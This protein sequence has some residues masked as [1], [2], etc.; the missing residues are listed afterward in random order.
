M[1]TTSFIN[2]QFQTRKM[3]SFNPSV[4]LSRSSLFDGLPLPSSFA[5]QNMFTTGSSTPTRNLSI[6][7]KQGSKAKC[8]ISSGDVLPHPNESSFTIDKE[9][10][11]HL[12]GIE[13]QPDMADITKFS[14]EIAP[15]SK[16]IS[17]K[18]NEYDLESPTRGFSSIPDAIEDIRQGK[19]V[20][21][22]D[23]EDRENEGDLIMAASLVTPQAMA[24]VVKHGTGIVCVS[25]R[26]DDLERLQLPLMVKQKENDDKLRTAFTVTVDAKYG[27]TTG[28]SAMDRAKTILG[29]ASKSSRPEDFNRPGHI[30]PLMYRE[31]GVLKRAGHTEASVDLAVLAGLEPVAVLSEVVDDDGSMARLPRLR[32]FAEEHNLNIISIAD[33]IRFR[34]KRDK[35]VELAGTAPIPTMWGPFATYCF[36]SMLDGTEHVAMVKGEI[37]DGHEIL[38]RVHLECLSGDVFGSARCKCGN[39]LELAMQQIEEEGRGILVYLRGC[40]GRGIGL[41]HKLRPYTVL[42]GEHDMVDDNEELGATLDSREYGIGAQILR[43]LGVVTMKLMTNNP[44]SYVGLKGYGLTIVGRVPLLTDTRFSVEEEEVGERA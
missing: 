34:R 40:E 20:I 1:P 7:H 41:N 11:K 42:E 33:L 6:S 5:Y 9:P 31:G 17:T 18:N 2:P 43:D 27:T 16:G 44:A 35:L 39:Q 3:I 29:L 12:N 15:K 21:V 25:M 14:A 8:T 19:F 10:L 13:I 37:G 23:D 38:V 24:F 32:Q 36:K 4:A 22:V 28:V 26:G 30:F